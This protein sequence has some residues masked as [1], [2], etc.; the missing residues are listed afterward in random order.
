MCIML[1]VLWIVKTVGYLKYM[2][3]YGLSIYEFIATM[4]LVM[5]NVLL[6]VIPFA[7]FIATILYYDRTVKSNELIIF[8]TLG[9]RKKQL[10]LPSAL[11]GLFG[12]VLSYLL[13]LYLIP[14]SNILFR[15]AI[16]SIENDIM[17][18]LLGS[19]SFNTLQ[20][21]TVYSDSRVENEIQSLVTYVSYSNNE[22]NKVIYAKSAKIL[23]DSHLR[24]YN[25]NIQ[26]YTTEAKDEMKILFFDE[27]DIDLGQ[28]YLIPAQ[29]RLEHQNTDFMYLN[30]LFI[31]KNKTIAVRG[32]ILSRIITP[33]L[34][35]LLSIV[36][37]AIAVDTHESKKSRLV[38]GRNIMNYAICLI[39]SIIF[40]YSA[41][42]A[43]INVLGFYLALVVLTLFTAC[44]L[45]MANRD[46]T[47]L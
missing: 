21:I 14:K 25:G 20:S 31:L 43:R 18:V 39:L 47:P 23:D 22:K 42:L 11:V 15:G 2:T 9:L 27:Q 46:I 5:P 45:A 29:D 30:E 10:V 4:S 7:T 35:L 1:S 38:N 33:I 37:A 28:F 19:K 40:L 13:T 34:S 3:K 32:E 26:E 16:K 36:S 8:K 12:C 41:R 6:L 24:L 44:T 17:N